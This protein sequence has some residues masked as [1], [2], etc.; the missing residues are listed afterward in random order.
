MNPLIILLMLL[1]FGTVTGILS[2]RLPMS[3][4]FAVALAFVPLLGL[5]C[6]FVFC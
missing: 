4:G 3:G 2:K 5:P 6:T 1:G